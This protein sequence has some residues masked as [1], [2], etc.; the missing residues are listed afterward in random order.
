MPE[1]LDTAQRHRAEYDHADDLRTGSFLLLRFVVGLLTIALPPLLILLD[2]MFLGG[3]PTARGSLSAYYHSGVR[4][5]FVAILV[6][7]GVF[8]ITYKVFERTLENVLTML[9]GLAAITVALFPV[10]PPAGV[11]PVPLQ[12]RLGEGVVETIHYGAAAVLFVSAALISMQFAREELDGPHHPD[13]SFTPQFWN[14]FHYVMSGVIV[15]AIIFVVVT[16]GFGV[17]DRFS[18]LLGEWVGLWAFGASWFAKGSDVRRLLF[19]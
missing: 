15:G 2:V 11:V 4:D 19:G 8:L 1:L 16:Q 3:S 13:Q 12:E 9:A 17:L 6:V 7:D 14:R 18:I 10:A 5:I